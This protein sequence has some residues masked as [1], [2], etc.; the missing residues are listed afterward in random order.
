MDTFFWVSCLFR[1]FFRQ[2]QEQQIVHFLYWAT[3]TKLTPNAV[4]RNIIGKLS[5]WLTMMTWGLHCCIVIKQAGS[6]GS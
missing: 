2:E 3:R 5:E 1:F 6:F 4:G